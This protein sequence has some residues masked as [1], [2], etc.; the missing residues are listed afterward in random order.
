MSCRY[1][2]KFSKGMV[3]IWDETLENC[4]NHWGH[5]SD[6]D[7]MVVCTKCKEFTCSNQK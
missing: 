2:G 1:C 5:W 4:I 3:N 6:Y 7:K